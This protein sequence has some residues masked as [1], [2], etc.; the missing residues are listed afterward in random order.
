VLIRTGTAPE[1]LL[2]AINSK[3]TALDDS[4]SVEVKPMNRALGLALLPSRVGAG[5]LGAI[6]VLGLLLASL[7]LYGVLLY[8]VSRRT[9]E[10]G[11]RVAIGARPGNIVGMVLAEGA[12]LVGLGIAIGVSIA[13]FVTKPLAMFLVPGLTPADPLTYAIVITVLTAVGILAS[14]FP[15]VRALRVDPIIALRY[16]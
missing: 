8:S 10:I 7:G 6:G 12:W 2:R 16:E 1:T 5:L 14:L 15:T 11:L 3:L 9:R 13:L 4:A